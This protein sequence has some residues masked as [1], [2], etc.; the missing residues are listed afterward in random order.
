M[1][2]GLFIGRFQPFHNGHLEVIKDYILP[3]CDKLIIGVGSS[4]YAYRKDNP[5]TYE[6]RKKMITDC[7]AYE[8]HIHNFEVVS[9]PDIHDATNWAKHVLNCVHEKIDVVFSGNDI[10]ITCFRSDIMRLHVTPESGPHAS[11]IR[12][13]LSEKG[14][15]GGMDMVP[16]AVQ[17]VLI[18]CKARE[19][20][21]YLNLPEKFIE[22]NL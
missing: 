14:N 2:I 6:E 19:R 8:H 22:K 16:L 21:Y 7:L 5:F 18:T 9:I 20:L 15:L 17:D 13:I 4:Q 1:S 12:K 10:T 3:K 11:D